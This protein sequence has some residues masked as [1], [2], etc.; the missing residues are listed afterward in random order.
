[1]KKGFFSALATF[2]TL[3]V[4]IFLFAF[5]TTRSLQYAAAGAIAFIVFM[6]V[7]LCKLNIV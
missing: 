1:M 4:V 7:L 3:I 6:Y 5:A 2:L